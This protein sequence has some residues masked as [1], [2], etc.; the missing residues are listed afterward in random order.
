MILLL[1]RK[2]KELNLLFL[3]LLDFHSLN[4]HNI[5]T[6]LL[7]EFQKNGHR[8]YV[9]SPSE[10]RNGEKTRIIQEKNANILKLRIGNTQ[11]TNLIEK[12][13]STL[14]IEPIFINGI[15]MYFSNVKFD[16]V[17]YS[18][19]P[20]TFCKAIEYVKKRDRAK[21]YLLLKDIFPQ[22]AVDLGMMKTTGIKGLLYQYFRNKEKK[23]YAISDHIGCMSPANV[24]Y[25]LKHNPE[26]DP[27]RVEVCPNCIEVVDKSVDAETRKQIRKKYQIPDEKMV[28]VYGGNL[29]KPQGIDFLIDCLRSQKNN[30][31]AFFLIIGDG[32]E[33]GKL[34]AFTESEPQEN[35]RLMQRLPKEDYD[36]LVG[37]CDVGMI[38]L[39]HRFTIPNFPSRL[40][41]YMQAKIPVLACTDPNTDIGKVITEG[42]FGWWCESACINKFNQSVGL[43]INNQVECIKAHE[44]E[45]L[46]FHYNSS[47][48]YELIKRGVFDESINDK[49]CMWC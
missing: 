22:N 28:F 45:F 25:V 24:E 8:V 5:Y 6:D 33:Y 17:M 43:I 15:K 38:F 20:I 16:L 9:V 37:A 21:T 30:Q 40:L 12:G 14:T 10:R 35:V 18:T 44:Y 1:E 4:E 3:T 31:A 48:V 29:G 39:D 41:S 42:G 27:K 23:L 46:L 49:C 19:P 32:T 47:Y 34:K 2:D 11:K 36:T 7:R 13:I 26:I